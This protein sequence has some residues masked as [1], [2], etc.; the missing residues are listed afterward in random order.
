MSLQ[1]GPVLNDNSSTSAK[2]T[3]HVPAVV[4]HGAFF[5]V[6]MAGDALAPARIKRD[7]MNR[8]PLTSH[9][10]KV[11][12]QRYIAAVTQATLAKVSF[13][14]IHLLISS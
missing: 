8:R 3:P 7:T 14:S 9:A 4:S 6:C 11:V 13:S 10:G 1:V 5:D 2:Q 12:P